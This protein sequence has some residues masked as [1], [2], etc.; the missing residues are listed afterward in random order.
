MET[1]R[2]FISVNRTLGLRLK[3][4]C[5]LHEPNLYA[6]EIT[7]I[8]CHEES[9]VSAWG[10]WVFKFNSSR[11]EEP[12]EKWPWTDTP[13][14]TTQW[15]TAWQ[16]IIPSVDQ[17]LSEKIVRCLKI[18]E[19]SLIFNIVSEANY[20][21]ILSGQKLTKNAQFGEF[22]KTWSLRSNSV[23]RQVSFNRTKIGGKCQNRTIQVRHF[24]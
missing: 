18:T 1:S 4:G 15:T 5:C 22:L 6:V 14:K 2:W 20:V 16:K 21:Y 11:T 7:F 17:E 12:E 9:S 13:R 10:Y 19:K 8:F 3:C 24:E 23:T